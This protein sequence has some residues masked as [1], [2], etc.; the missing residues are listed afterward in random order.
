MNAD[1]SYEQLKADYDLLKVQYQALAA[2][3][4]RFR[5]ARQETVIRINSLICMFASLERKSDPI[6]NKNVQKNTVFTLNRM[7]EKNVDDNEPLPEAADD[8]IPTYLKK[9]RAKRKN[10]DNAWRRKYK[11]LQLNVDAE[12]RNL[13]RGIEIVENQKSEAKK[14]IEEVKIKKEKLID[15][16]TK[17][18]S[19]KSKLEHKA[20][21]GVR[22]VKIKKEA[23]EKF[24]E[25]MM[26]REE[27]LSKERRN[28]AAEKRKFRSNQ[29]PDWTPPGTTSPSKR[30]CLSRVPNS[31]SSGGSGAQRLAGTSIPVSRIDQND[32]E[33]SADV[34]PEIKQEAKPVRDPAFERFDPSR[35]R[36]ILD[37][38]AKRRASDII[39]LD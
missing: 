38:G 31:S 7:L 3:N 33:S 29:D 4:C 14:T 24:H 8:E 5:S 28:F 6:L 20:E 15:D 25:N 32:N 12:K 1:K 27:K 11:E 21:Q 26:E 10:S 13:K 19:V 16:K 9:I 36:P 17:F 35:T 2:Q 30:P 18:E 34:K 23:V 22:M 37:R 39:I